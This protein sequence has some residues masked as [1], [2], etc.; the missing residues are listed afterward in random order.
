M[1]SVNGV[2]YQINF[3][4]TSFAPTAMKTQWL[5]G[6]GLKCDHIFKTVKKAVK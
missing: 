2:H 6:W 5:Y 4:L 3:Y 1:F